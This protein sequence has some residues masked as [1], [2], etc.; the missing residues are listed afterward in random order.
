MVEKNKLDKDLQGTPVNATLYRGMIGSLIYLTSSR[1]DLS[2]AVCLC[3]RYQARPTEKHLHAVKQIFRYLKGTINIGIWYSK[4]TGDKLVSWS[5]KKQKSTA[6]SS[7]EAEYFALSGC[8]ALDQEMVPSAERVKI[9]STNIILETTIPQKEETLQVVIDMIK[10][11]TCLKAFTIFADVLEIFMQQFFYTIKKVKDSDSYEFLLANKKCIVNAEV[12]RIILDICPRVEGVDFT[13]VLDDDTTLTFLIN[14]GYKG[15]LNRHTNMFVDHMHQPWR[16]LAAIINK[17]LSGKTT[18]NEK[19]RMSRIDIQWGMFNKASVDY[20]V[21]IWEDI[22]YHINHKKEK[23]SRHENMPVQN[24][25]RCSSHI[26]LIRFHVR[27]VERKTSSKRRVKKKFT[28]SDDDNI[29]FDDPN[30]ALE[31]AKSISQTKAEKAEA[32]RK[33]H[34]THARI[35][36][37]YTSKAKLKG[38]L[39]FTPEEQEAADIIQALKESK[40]MSRKQSGSRGS[41]E[42]TSSIPRVLDESIVVFAPS[43][44]GPGTKPGVPDEDKVIIEEKVLLEWGDK[45]DDDDVDEDDDD[46]VDKDGDTD[47]KGDDQD[48]DDKD[49]ET[50]D[51]DIN[52]YKICSYVPI[53]VD[54]YLDSKLTKKPTPTVEQ[55]SEK[56]PSDIL[57]IKKEQ[58]EK[59]KIP[60]YTIKS[61][62]KAALEEYD[63]KSALYQS[64][65]TNKV[66]D[67]VKDHKRKHDDDE[68]GDDEGPLARPNQGKKTKRRRTKESESIKK[69]STTKE[70]PK[71]KAPTKGSKTGKSASAKKPVE[72]PNAEMIMNDAGNDV[73]CDDD[74]P[75]AASEPK[76]YKTQNP[77]LFKQPPRP[78]TLDLEWNKRQVVLD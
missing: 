45:D 56:S 53:V 59:Q 31:L 11:S 13:D 54:S 40:K 33:V 25:T 17:C 12:F 74:Q 43:S 47:D 62:N 78:P 39:S 9:S 1:P 52:K 35:S 51:D 8:C 71:D 36:K 4:D 27:K 58:A 23:R 2:Y 64:M 70:T 20:P 55:E 50:D 49:E 26:P 19:I 68:D 38:V 69:P 73:V 30:A 34:D 10:N 63:L 46:D 16:T 14:L 60:K 65:H 6:I 5:S 72:E 22:A 15:L 76:T 21:L 28:L 3:A 7:T 57:K 61:T 29:I 75:Q 24:H 67:T 42:G 37:P 44:E 66:A 48:A 32:A 41:G 18:S 77:E